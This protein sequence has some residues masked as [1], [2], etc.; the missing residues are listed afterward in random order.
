MR[1]IRTRSPTPCGPRGESAAAQRSARLRPRARRG[2]FPGRAR[3]AQR[4]RSMPR[5]W[6]GRQMKV[7]MLSP[8]PPYPLNGGGAFRTASLLHYFARFAEVDLILISET[9][10]P[11]LLP[12]GTGALTAGDPA[13][14]PQPQSRRALPAQCQP[15]RPRR[16]AA[17]RPAGRSGTAAGT[18]VRQA[19]AMTW[20]SWSISGALPMSNSCRRVRRNGPRSAQHRIGAA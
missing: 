3:R 4:T 15:G 14:A 20:G 7:V 6:A 9:G 12:A 18:R 2:I 11:A 16:A 5:C 13:A 17:D 19:N 1:R 10:Q 8:E